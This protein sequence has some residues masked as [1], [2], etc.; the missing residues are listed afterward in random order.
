[1]YRSEDKRSFDHCETEADTFDPRLR[2]ALR[3]ATTG[4]S[5]MAAFADPLSVSFAISDP[6]QVEEGPLRTVAN[7]Q[8]DIVEQVEL[9]SCGAAIAVAFGKKGETL[10]TV[11][12][13]VLAESTVPRAHIRRDPPLH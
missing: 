13:A 12:W 10:G 2:S 4:V 9:F 1:M 6:S 3:P 8:A 7:I 5:G 11:E